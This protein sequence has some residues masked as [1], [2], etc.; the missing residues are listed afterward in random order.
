[1]NERNG[2]R[3]LLGRMKARLY[4]LRREDRGSILVLA[5]AGMFGTAA[6]AGLA[7]DVGKVHFDRRDVQN[8][9]D[10]SALAGASRLLEGGSPSEVTFEARSWLGKNGNASAAY[11]SNVYYPP[12]TGTYAGNMDC[13]EAAT[14]HTLNGFFMPLGDKS[15]KARAVACMEHDWRKYAVV[16]LNS[17]ACDSFTFVGNVHFYINGAGTFN[18]SECESQATHFNGDNLLYSAEN[19][20]VGGVR[21]DG[22]ADV[23]PD[24]EKAPHID[25]PLAGLP[26]VSGS[27]VARTCPNLTGAAGGSV[28]LQPGRYNCTISPSGGTWRVTFAPG[29]YE[30]TGGIVGDASGDRFTL[31]AGTYNLGGQGLRLTGSSRMTAT[32]VTFYIA[33]GCVSLTG[34]STLSLTAPASGTYKHVLIFQA[35]TNTCGIAI[36]GNGAAGNDG[37]VYAPAARITYSGNVNSTLQFISDKFTADAG[38]CGETSFSSQILFDVKEVKLK[39]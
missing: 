17:T 4:R 38:G 1:M 20:V 5:A 27:S 8:G 23:S 15:V 2:I 21:I 13:V 35:R 7:I 37:T 9:V 14:D 6:L 16:A 31:G 34:S 11:A 33:S 32:G 30:I 18:N 25:D 10:A 39:E 12:T 26:A 29:S 36:N 28:T 22:T 3:R 24:F 19:R